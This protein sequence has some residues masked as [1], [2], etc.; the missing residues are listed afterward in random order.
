MAV[1]NVEIARDSCRHYTMQISSFLDFK[2]FNQN[3]HYRENY[4][5][6]TRLFTLPPSIIHS[7][8]PENPT[9]PHQ[10]DRFFSA[11]PSHLS[12]D[13]TTIA[14]QNDRNSLAK[15]P[16]LHDKRL[17]LIAHF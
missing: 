10:N 6:K 17:L 13:S 3:L 16:L 1:Q 4:T 9:S 2:K 7:F 14:P 15:R 11:K 8:F 12:Y 5:P